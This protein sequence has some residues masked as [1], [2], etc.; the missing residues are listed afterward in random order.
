MWTIIDRAELS[1]TP[2]R[3]LRLGADAT[4]PDLVAAVR[5]SGGLGFLAAGYLTP[6]K[7]TADIVAVRGAGIETFGVNLFVPEDGQ[8]VDTEDVARYRALLQP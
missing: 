4:T 7:L 6:E 1:G 8:V 5:N 2:D 3:R